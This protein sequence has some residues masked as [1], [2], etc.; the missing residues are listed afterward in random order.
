MNLR[1]IDE[2]RNADLRGSFPALKR[3]AQR[4]RAL[5]ATTGTAFIV[6]R[7]DVVE[8]APPDSV[9]QQTP[10]ASAG[11]PTTDHHGDI[12][13]PD[14]EEHFQREDLKWGLRGDD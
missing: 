6:S 13:D 3:A 14:A 8:N 5:A 11:I 9:P 7:D 2:A 12:G 10:I 1:P 4:A